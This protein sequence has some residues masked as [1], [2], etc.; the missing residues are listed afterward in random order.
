MIKKTIFFSVV[1]VAIVVFAV[2][3]ANKKRQSRVT[4]KLGHVASETDPL[5][6]AF[7]FYAEN[8]KE[9][10]KGR[11][12][13]EVYPGGEL[14]TNKEIYE[15]AHMGANIIANVDPGYLS[16]YV[17]DMGIVLGPYLGLDPQKFN[18]LLK[19]DWY[20]EAAR[21]L[22]EKGFKIL[23]LKM[24]SGSRNIIADKPI[25]TLED[26]KSLTIRTPPNVMCIET[27]K[28]LGATLVEL[29]WNEAYLGLSHGIVDAAEAQLGSIWGSKL[30]QVKKYISMTGHFKIF[31]G[32]AI[33]RT[34][35]ETLTKD[36][37][38]ILLEEANKTADF[39]TDLT[40]NS[41][42]DLKKKFEAE[43]V[44]FVYDID[45]TAFQKATESVYMTFPDWT[46]GLHENIKSI[47]AQPKY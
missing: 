5:H 1:S 9:R 41:Q 18:K 4:I 43:G 44:S 21:K 28:A 32:M 19:S 39:L 29:P 33:G 2:W 6:R 35:W 14:G 47:L 8:V 27:F 16:F 17:P 46:P 24:F 36:V 40:V 25:R 11:V 42:A 20:K 22:Y 45:F 37:Q 3:T 12:K 23:T 10:T 38:K 13:I 15:K 34:Y 26:I 7:E 30:Y 31:S